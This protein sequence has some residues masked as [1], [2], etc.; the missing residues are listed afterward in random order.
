[1]ENPRGLVVR[2]PGPEVG[3]Q[4]GAEPLGLADVH[5]PSR[6]VGKDCEALVTLMKRITRA[7]PVMWRLSIVGFGRDHY[8]WPG[9][10]RQDYRI[11][12]MRRNRGSDRSASTKGL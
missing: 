9:V 5:D 6:R 7:D 1:M 3:E 11:P 8:A 10:H 2:E 12:I 4:S